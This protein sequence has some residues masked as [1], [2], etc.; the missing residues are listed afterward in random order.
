MEFIRNVLE[1]ENWRLWLV[2]VVSGLCLTAVFWLG[3][4]FKNDF[5]ADD[6]QSQAAHIPMPH[7]TATQVINKQLQF[8]LDSPLADER[9]KITYL[10]NFASRPQQLTKK[11]VQMPYSVLFSFQKFMFG[12][13]K[14]SSQKARQEVVFIAPDSTLVILRF[15]LIKAQQGAYRNCWLISD[16]VHIKPVKESI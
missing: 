7:Y 15:E 14:F 1:G 9:Q 13:H 11:L 6:A 12:E 3:G 2:A 5:L 16:I 4:L 10:L 8:M